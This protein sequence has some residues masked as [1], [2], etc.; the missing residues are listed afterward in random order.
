MPPILYFLL[1]EGE[2]LTGLVRGQDNCHLQPFL[3]PSNILYPFSHLISR[4]HESEKQ[5]FC[6]LKGDLP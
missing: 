3:S 6:P 1:T 5:P 4:H 2:G